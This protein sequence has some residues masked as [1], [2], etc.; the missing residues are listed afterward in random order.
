MSASPAASDTAEGP[1]Q[2]TITA[3]FWFEAESS[4]ASALPC[5]SVRAMATVEIGRSAS[6]I[7]LMFAFEPSASL[8]L[9]RASGD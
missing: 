7:G 8:I 4:A 3:T 5:P 6:A 1:S 2:S 9:G